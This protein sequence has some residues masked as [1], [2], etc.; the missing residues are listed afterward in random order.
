MQRLRPFLALLFVATVC[1]MAYWDIASYQDTL[2]WDMMD[3][4]YPWRYFVGEC[5]SHKCFPLWNPYQHLGYPIHADMR[6]V[7]YP[8]GFLVG[9]MGG[10]QLPVLHFLF[11][12]YISMAGM[13]LYMLAGNFMK[14]EIAKLTMAAAY[15]LCG[16]FVGHGQEM[17]G[18]IAATWIPWVLHY[19]IRFQSNYGWADLWKLAFFL[20]L[21][22]T[23]GYQALS[24]IL[25]YLLLAI[26][27]V[28]M[29][30]NHLEN[31]NATLQTGARMNLM[32]GGV[33]LLS[34]SV[35][36]ITY[37]QVSPHVERL[38]GLS[39]DD[40]NV[41]LLTPQALIS[42]VAPFSVA[43]DEIFLGTNITMANVYVG[44]LVLVFYLLG[45]A[46]RKNAVLMVIWIFGLFTLLA[47]LGPHTPVREILYDHVPGM[48]LFRMSSFFSY[49]SQL[50]FLLVAGM[51]LDEVLKNPS[52]MIRKLLA[53]A[54]VVALGALTLV[55]STYIDRPT[56]SSVAFAHLF[57]FFPS[58]S[59]LSYHQRL[60]YQ[61][62]VQVLVVL[63]FMLIAF[64]LRE[65]KTALSVF[66]L[67]LVVAE[68][69]MALRLNFSSTVGGGFVPSEMQ[70]DLDAQPDG[71]PVPS[72]AFPLRMFPDGIREL[73]P[74]WHNTN[75][76]SKT[77]SGDG[78]NSFRLDRFENYRLE[79]EAQFKE[80]LT[81]PLVYSPTDAATIELTDLGPGRITC[82]VSAQEAGNIIL[83][84]TYYEGWEVAVDGKPCS[85]SLHNDIFPMVSVP[86]GET[87]VVFEY[88]NDG[89]LAGFGLSYLTLFIIIIG[90]IYHLFLAGTNSQTALVGAIV[91]G[92]MLIGGIG[93]QWFSLNTMDESRAE[94]YSRLSSLME[95]EL[96]GDPIIFLGVD[97]PKVFRKMIDG[98]RNRKLMNVLDLKL[99]EL[100]GFQ[101]SLED[102]TTDTVIYAGSNFGEDR[103][104][105]ELIRENYPAQRTKRSGREFMHVFTKGEK[106]KTLFSSSIDFE[107][108]SSTWNYN[109]TRFDRNA[110]VHSGQLGWS[111]HSG[112]MGSPDLTV[113][114]GDITE[115]KRIKMIYRS[116]CMVPKGAVSDA[117]L[118]VHVERAGQDSW[119]RATNINN[120]AP[121]DH[122]WFLTAFLVEPDFDLEPDDVLKVF[123]WGGEG[124]PI[125]L[126]DQSFTVYP[127]NE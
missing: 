44:I 53:A 118:F 99:G 119:M 84:Q 3:C 97:K 22:L 13:G 35:L 57:E 28:L 39:L 59:E 17:F 8:E 63:S 7:Y 1:V 95:A 109:E 103:L 70:A 85:I 30:K 45:S 79:N 105:I 71:F 21:Q 50:S 31:H 51:A 37:N 111:I 115:L 92:L 123:V 124:E 34:M 126:D 25:F 55:I 23:G 12:F 80:S 42:I 76:F 16:F 66:V 116:W 38:T 100:S 87:T 24:L 82:L 2:K 94:A 18:I 6:S 98:E 11:I 36:L 83:Q 125:H 48:N 112:Q 86:K 72:N 62:S 117:A 10:Y 46:L 67:A 65:R 122:N 47:S 14:G 78:F 90:I 32:L 54:T 52:R 75:I 108:P 27:M 68:M 73:D 104:L 101:A 110:K 19:F 74:L 26:F 93:F 127:A 88:R 107:T 121:K 106:R 120:R 15:V 56:E 20:F 91:S 102:S 96:V 9:L 5:V 29:V 33:V 77:V 114:V 89:V 41:G 69:T 64:L 61:S 60:T 40:S 43:T 58:F 113:R 49:F 4:Y 81:H